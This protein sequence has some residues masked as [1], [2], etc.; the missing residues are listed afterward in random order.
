MNWRT[1]QSTARPQEVDTTS[2]KIVNYVRQNIH[3]VQI[4]DM[5][6]QERTVYEYDELEVNKESWPMYLELEQAKADIDFLN[7]ITE[8]L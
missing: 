5:D 1:A 4:E 2:S 3:M 8:D 6:G 7:M